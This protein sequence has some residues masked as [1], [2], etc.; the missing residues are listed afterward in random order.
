MR[1]LQ[2]TSVL[3][4]RSGNYAC[5]L[6]LAYVAEVMRP[7]ATKP[8][9][10]TSETV[11]GLAVI[12][13]EPTPV[14]DLGALLGSPCGDSCTRFVTIRLG[15]RR[16]ALG[17]EAVLGIRELASELLAELPPLLHEAQSG[18]VEAIGML[19]A[20]L[21]LLFRA[22]RLVPEEVWTAVSQS[23]DVNVPA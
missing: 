19:D 7:L 3:V 16:A 23:G 10:G 18:L 6:P 21:L 5:A 17:V 1:D 9:P 12:R 22:S 8:L 20:D 15:E 13:G 14:I 4:M 11:R 2:S